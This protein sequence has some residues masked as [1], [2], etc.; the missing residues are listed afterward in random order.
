M[1]WDLLLWF[2]LLVNVIVMLVAHVFWRES[3]GTSENHCSLIG[4][5]SSPE[6][7]Q[8]HSGRTF[9]A[10]VTIAPIS[11]SIQHWRVHA[12]QMFRGHDH[13]TEYVELSYYLKL[14]IP[15]APPYSK[16]YYNAWYAT[17]TRYV[18]PQW[19]MHSEVHYDIHEL[20]CLQLG[21]IKW[22]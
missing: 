18:R 13:S 11:I 5:G 8:L 3:R 12:V 2:S 19:D 1:S 22:R 10:P 17:R 21:R 7:L 6:I 15:L 4:A 9:R 20:S 16:W 14:T